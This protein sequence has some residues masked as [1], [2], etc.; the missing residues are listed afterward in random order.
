M[1]GFCDPFLVGLSFVIAVAA[2]S[3]GLSLAS[4]MA[5]DSGRA[6]DVWL[7]MA[8]LALGGGIWS[9][10]FVAMLAFSLPGM[11]MSYEPWTTLV[12]FLIPV[13]LTVLALRIVAP[14]HRSVRT[15]LPGGLLMGGVLA[16]H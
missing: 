15:L 8:A 4:R 11:S 10:H 7:A 6:R 2:S 12:S 3:A 13:L 14:Q 5:N 9:M 1:T 16:M